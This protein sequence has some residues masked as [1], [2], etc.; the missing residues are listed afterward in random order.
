MDGWPQ[1]EGESKEGSEYVCLQKVLARDSSNACASACSRSRLEKGAIRGGGSSARRPFDS[2]ESYLCSGM[3]CC[4]RKLLPWLLVCEMCE[5]LCAR[6]CVCACVYV[7]VIFSP[8]FV[9]QCF[10]YVSVRAR[11][12]I[13][14]DFMI[15]LYGYRQEDSN[16][17]GSNYCRVCGEECYCR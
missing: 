14:H 4:L 10:E 15:A 17:K 2:S 12:Y 11:A 7:I 8:P 9:S 5:K 13:P 16:V 6:A 3:V 1:K